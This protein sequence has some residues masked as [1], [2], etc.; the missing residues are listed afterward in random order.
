[1]TV[2]ALAPVPATHATALG[3]RSTSRHT[4][5][6]ELIA[7]IAYG[8]R[9][10]MQLLYARHNVRVYRF[11]LSII[12]NDASAE[13]VVS[14]TF[15]DVWQQ[16]DRFEGRSKVSTWLMSIARHK[17]LSALRSRQ[18]DAIE[19]HAE[20]LADVADTPETSMQKTDRTELLRDCLAKLTPA[21]RE[22]I[23]LVYYQEKKIEEVAEILAIPLN[24]VK[25]RMHYARKRLSELLGAAGFAAAA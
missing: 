12:R 24:T 18:H 5:D 25:T 13:D 10:A 19:D 20:T 16:A 7:A 8:D 3:A 14:E 9:L 22:I 11:A 1:M 23:N 2:R 6:E 4:S 17:A 21:H 15:I